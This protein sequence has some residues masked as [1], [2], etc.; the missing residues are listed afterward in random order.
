MKG[1][2]WVVWTTLAGIVKMGS[3]FVKGY[4][5][6]ADAIPAQQD[7]SPQQRA[8][9]IEKIARSHVFFGA[10]TSYKLL[11]FLAERSFTEPHIPL[12]EYE[13]ATE[14]M[15]RRN[16]FD[17]RS[18]SSVRVQVARLRTKLAEYMSGEGLE[19]PYIVE[20]PRGSYKLIMAPNPRAQSFL[21]DDR[22][23]HPEV[24]PAYAGDVAGIAHEEPHEPLQKDRVP[25]RNWKILTAVFILATVSLGLAYRFRNYIH[26]GR[27]VSV[28]AAVR[29]FWQP[30]LSDPQGPLTIVS[31][32]PFTGNAVNGLRYDQQSGKSAGTAHSYYTGIGEAVSIH[33][34]DTLFSQLNSPLRVRPGSQLSVEDL[35]DSNL[36]FIGAP[37]ENLMVKKV[38]TLK[39]FEFQE[40][41]TGPRTGQVVIQNRE[42]LPGEPP[43][44]MASSVPDAALVDDYALIARMPIDATH[45]AIVAAGTTT[46]GTEAAV[47]YLCQPDTLKQLQQKLRASGHD[48]TYEL[49]LHI[50][51]VE[52][53]PMKVEIVTVR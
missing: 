35:K 16:D 15:G 2:R 8:A 46:I 10:E 20:V 47:D 19:D 14:V 3:D 9:Q 12:K 23:S 21:L 39:H 40:L 43:V 33:K 34:L 41:T 26:F 13:I 5:M 11:Y 45:E 28:D 6:S 37:V 42:P 24:V 48:G 29:E 53:V 25:R 51:V 36:I 22:K 38:V 32:A 18:D 27:T 30:F 52:D 7:I 17:P 44:Y 50:K 31:N 4:G 1:V 49:I